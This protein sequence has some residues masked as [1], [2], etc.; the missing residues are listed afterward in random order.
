[1]SYTVS[2][3]FSQE[4]AKRAGAEPINLYVLNASQTG[5]DYK[6]YANYNQNVYGYRLDANGDIT[7]ST[8]LYVGLPIE[9]DEI[10][11][12]TTGE[13][14]NI[15]VSIPN[16]DR[17]VE[18]FIQNQNYLRGKE[19]YIMTTFAKSLP[20]GDSPQYVGS[21]SDKNA[22][23]KEKLF[24][25]TATSN[26]QVVTFSCKPKF[27]IKHAVIPN[28]NFSRECAWALRNKY[29]ATECDPLGSIDTVTYTTCDGTLDNCKLRQNVKRFGGFPSIPRRG[30]VIV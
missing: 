2:A 1:M 23:L 10:K 14:T 25:D 5:V 3:T 16:T 29:A 26:E 12:D 28:R 8:T 21:E 20:S 17:V 22:V 7:N 24:I 4:Q 30:I 13:I 19:I 15:G 18:S 6:Y 9:I 11:S 27:L